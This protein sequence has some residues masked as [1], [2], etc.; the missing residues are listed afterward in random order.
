MAR[1]EFLNHCLDNSGSIPAVNAALTPGCYK[2]RHRNA[3][4][5]TTT[6]QER[7]ASVVFSLAA[8]SSHPKSDADRG[9][10][11][12]FQVAPRGNSDWVSGARLWRSPAAAGP[13]SQTLQTIP[14]PN[15]L[16][17]VLWTQSR[18]IENPNGIPSQPQ[19]AARN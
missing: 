18:S 9:A 10:S 6:E 5:A 12:F 17:L 15:A 4:S 14:L 7:T 16:R 19:G 3:Q 8:R 1:E 11:R 2:Q 13:N